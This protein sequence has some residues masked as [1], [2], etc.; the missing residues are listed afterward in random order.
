MITIKLTERAFE[1]FYGASSCVLLG[2]SV[3]NA[4]RRL[5]PEGVETLCLHAD[6]LVSLPSER[7]GADRTLDPIGM[8][9][10][11][12]A[13]AYAK[14]RA[15]AKSWAAYASEQK[16]HRMPDLVGVPSLGV[17]AR[18]RF[19]EY[20]TSYLSGQLAKAN[21]DLSDRES[22]LANLRR[23]NEWLLLNLEMMRRVIQG[24]GY[25]SRSVSL[26]VPPGAAT[27]GPSGDQTM[28]Q[29]AQRLPCDIVGLT[30]ISLYF[31]AKE[32][33]SADGNL[34]LRVVRAVDGAIVASATQPYRALAQ[35][36]WHTFELGQV[37]P[38]AFGAANLELAWQNATGG[39]SVNACLGAPD[40]DRFGD[41]NGRSLAMRVFRGVVDPSD[42]ACEDDQLGPYFP[43]QMRLHDLR[44][45]TTTLNHQGVADGGNGS[46]AGPGGDALSYCV[47]EGWLETHLKAEGATGVV[48]KGAIPTDSV[49][50][51]IQVQTAHPAAPPVVY[52]MAAV[53]P[54]LS[55]HE[56]GVAT[57]LTDLAAKVTK[58]GATRDAGHAPDIGVH[59]CSRL[60]QANEV[61][62]LHLELPEKTTKPL[63]VYLLVASTKN[64]ADYGWC[65]W[66]NLRCNMD[67]FKP[68]QQ[69]AD[70]TEFRMAPHL[71]QVSQRFPDIAGRVQFLY[72]DVAL[73]KL[74]AELGFTPFQISE[75]SGAM[76][77]HPLEGKVSAAVLAG[78][79][80]Q[81]SLRVRAEVETAHEYAPEFIY[82]LAVL[83][84]SDEDRVAVVEKLAAT[85]DPQRPETLTGE[86]NGVYWTSVKVGARTRVPLELELANPL[87]QRS[88]IIFAALPAADSMAFGWCRW[89]ILSVITSTSD[90]AP[91]SVQG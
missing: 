28:F 73:K 67:V 31:Q 20:L 42:A 33:V 27:V 47:S 23:K 4:L 59:W 10:G 2:K 66:S 55:T 46:D 30:A 17:M 68:Q 19:R 81:S 72:G 18:M 39:S 56:E 61:G 82:L 50:V 86:G 51:Q 32:G 75:E 1:S 40:V 90:Q 74:A 9:S 79:A 71:R 29:Y 12:F 48:I 53:D 83:E 16:L 8:P 36:G 11:L 13:I 78:G 54:D 49:S 77:T 69:V 25:E 80:P 62:Y 22:R 3:I 6:G 70:L 7:L 64:T 24:A 85:L 57:L 88:D 87:R 38:R 60:T 76:Q 89:H 26:E 91:V 52:F 15:P 44:E 37:V 43:F 5:V 41:E 65:R 14:E 45:S 63:D 58:T 34:C 21:G 35:G 84:P